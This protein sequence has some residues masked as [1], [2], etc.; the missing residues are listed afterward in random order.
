MAD[1]QGL[2]K[3][4]NML[5]QLLALQEPIF[6]TASDKGFW[7]DKEKRNKG[8]MV[9]LIISELGEA[10][11]SRRKGR[12]LPKFNPVSFE[13]WRNDSAGT[14]AEYNQLWITEFEQNVKDWVPD[15]ISDVAIRILDYTG[16]WKIP[17]I[18]RDYRKESTG[19]FGHDVLRLVWYIMLA[20]EGGRENGQDPSIEFQE[21]HPGKDWGY[22]LAA[23]IKFCEWY[24]INLIQ[25][26]KWK[27]K[28]NDTRPKLHGK[29]Y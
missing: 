18:E 9:M 7:D 29:A 15:E 16:G 24:N 26:C 27:M 12:T 11:E 28:Y 8:E 2:F 5:Q 25:H 22:V 6:K 19:N 14:I 10:V 4:T 21:A 23:I 13:V 1:V 3:T 20:F 17:T